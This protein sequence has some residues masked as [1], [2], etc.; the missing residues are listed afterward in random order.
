MP[1]GIAGPSSLVRRFTCSFSTLISDRLSSN[2]SRLKL[3]PLHAGLSTDEQLQ[4]FQPAGTGTRKVIISTNI[5][6]V[7]IWFLSRHLT[8]FL[9]ISPFQASVTV[10]GVKFVVDCGFVKVS[11]FSPSSAMH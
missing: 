3:L 6:E 2:A 4:V 7:C 9:N 11:I 10:D 8:G 5:A 1:P